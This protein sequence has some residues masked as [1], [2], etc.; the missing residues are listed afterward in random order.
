MTVLEVAWDPGLVE[1]AVLL[2]VR[3]PRVEPAFRRERDRLYEIGDRGA[4]ETAFAAFH[5]RWFQ[6]LGLD[7]P[8]H[9][10]L[11][12]LPVLAARCGR[13]IVARALGARDEYADLLVAPSAPPTMLVRLTA[14][15][16][17]VRDRALTFLRSELLHV[18]D[19]LDPE[20]GYAPCLGAGPAGAPPEDRLWDRY[21][22]LWNTSID[23]RLA[24]QGRAALEAKARRWQDFRRAFPD[25]GPGAEA[26]FER[27]WSA[28]RCPH[29]EL[30]A[31]AAGASRDAPG[32]EP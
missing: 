14:E 15:T 29:A 13:G 22:V 28:E 32:K 6:R 21:R 10:V 30:V 9:E 8:L 16:L 1:A 3:D 25:L 18:A 11:S 2:A 7:G 26:A 31:L 24:R 20:F 5:A 12:E 4:R 17:S 27:V 19:M 23:G